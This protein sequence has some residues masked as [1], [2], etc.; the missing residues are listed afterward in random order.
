[1]FLIFFDMYL[2][3]C[4]MFCQHF[5]IFSQYAAAFLVPGVKGLPAGVLVGLAC[6][7]D[8]DPLRSYYPI[9]RNF[10]LGI[11]VN[12]FSRGA[13]APDPPHSRSAAS[14]IIVLHIDPR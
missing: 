8:L 9:S 14:M 4:V 11:F 7:A 13:S 1:M 5:D 10:L 3:L 2:I 6:H 12:L